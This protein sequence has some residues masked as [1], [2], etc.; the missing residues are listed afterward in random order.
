ALAAGSARLY[1]APEAGARLL[2]LFLRGGYDAASVL[3]PYSS[4]FYYQARPNIALPK[5]DVLRLDAD[6]GLHPALRE[7]VHR[8]YLA[9]EAAFVPFAGSDD[10]S[11]SHFET[12]D[13]IELGQ[14]V[15]GSR[16]YGSGF[17]NRLMTALNG[18]RAIAFSDQL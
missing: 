18:E 3:V 14:P 1:A 17:L 16:D 5:G 11:R 6:W 13:S 4:D 9:G 2:V 8:F 7:S 12:Q 15:G 10:R